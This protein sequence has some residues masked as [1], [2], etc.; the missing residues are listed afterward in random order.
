MTDSERIAALEKDIRHTK[1]ALTLLKKLCEL[2]DDR[3]DNLEAFMHMLT[4][5]KPN[6]Y[7]GVPPQD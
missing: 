6:P 3:I 7:V 4:G 2:Q 1:E 5:E